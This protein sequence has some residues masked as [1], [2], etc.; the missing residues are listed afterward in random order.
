MV[1]CEP[2]T[3]SRLNFE[4]Y[5]Y[6]ALVVL[7]Y[8]DLISEDTEETVQMSSKEKLLSKFRKIPGKKSRGGVDDQQARML[9]T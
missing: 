9:K 4:T 8:A 6:N 7:V 3:F 5:I 2:Q 1:R